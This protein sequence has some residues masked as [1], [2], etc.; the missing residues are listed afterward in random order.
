[1][2][3]TILLAVKTV[4]LRPNYRQLTITED[5]DFKAQNLKWDLAHH[6]KTKQNKTKQSQQLYSDF[7]SNN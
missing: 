7:I 5:Y 2:N 1:M 6:C 4:S 3:L